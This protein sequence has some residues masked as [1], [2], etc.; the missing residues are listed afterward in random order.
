MKAEREKGDALALSL[1]RSHHGSEV[2]GTEIM[3]P[4]MEPT[5]E[6]ETRTTQSDEND[7]DAAEYKGNPKSPTGE[8][9]NPAA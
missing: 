2:R 9:A 5:S 8:E 7:S 3:L 1:S 4:S 6:S